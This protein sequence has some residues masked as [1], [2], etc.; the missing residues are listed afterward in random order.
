MAAVRLLEDEPRFEVSSFLG[1]FATFAL[2]CSFCIC[3]FLHLYLLRFATFCSGV[4]FC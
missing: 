4:S 1:F 3:M 2:V